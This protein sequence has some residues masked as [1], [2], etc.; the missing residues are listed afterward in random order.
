MY[1][2]V[3]T[4]ETSQCKWRL[5][6]Y[7][8]VFTAPIVFDSRN[9]LVLY[10]ASSCCVS[11]LPTWRGDSPANNT[12]RQFQKISENVVK[13]DLYVQFLCMMKANWQIF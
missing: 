6:K 10:N 12:N 5:D 4:E 13:L 9:V 11:G 3:A 8:D 7:I 2:N 1:V